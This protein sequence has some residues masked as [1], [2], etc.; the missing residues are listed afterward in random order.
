LAVILCWRRPLALIG[1]VGDSSSEVKTVYT[2]TH[3]QPPI[4]QTWEVPDRP[5]HLPLPCTIPSE[6]ER[7]NAHVVLQHQQI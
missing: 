5:S 6:R 4:P 3:T 7:K 1:S 2:H